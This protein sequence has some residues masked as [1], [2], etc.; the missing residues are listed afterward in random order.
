MMQQLKRRIEVL[1]TCRFG[2]PRV[3]AMRRRFGTM[4]V[5]ELADLVQCLVDGRLND[6]SPLFDPS[7]LTEEEREAAIALVFVPDTD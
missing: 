1:E 4:S 5:E 2:S 6:L 7:T 3:A